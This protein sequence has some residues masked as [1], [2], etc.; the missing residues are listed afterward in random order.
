MFR[1]PPTQ[2]R[3]A[4]ADAAKRI[5]ETYRVDRR[6][7]PIGTNVTAT[8]TGDNYGEIQQPQE[9]HRP[10]TN[11]EAGIYVVSAPVNL[12][13]TQSEVDNRSMRSNMSRSSL[14][15]IEALDKNRQ[16]REN[17]FF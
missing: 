7:A 13:K 14:A 15:K 5:A 10:N 12:Q 6:K 8:N 1:T 11:S 17:T 2:V 3:A 4:K 9:K 16:A